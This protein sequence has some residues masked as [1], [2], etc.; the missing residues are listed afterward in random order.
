MLPNVQFHFSETDYYDDMW[1]NHNKIVGLI[2]RSWPEETSLLLSYL[3]RGLKPAHEAV[4]LAERVEFQLTGGQLV[5]FV[6]QE[7]HW[8][9]PTVVQSHL[10][11]KEGKVTIMS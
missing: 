10:G 8:D 9:R 6:G 4:F 2:S 3:G 5:R 1:H 11:K 7:H